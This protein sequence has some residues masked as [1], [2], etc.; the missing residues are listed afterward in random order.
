MFILHFAY[1]PIVEE[2]IGELKGGIHIPHDQIFG[3][4]DPPPHR[5]PKIRH[6]NCAAQ[7]ENSCSRFLIYNENIQST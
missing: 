2:F 1:S 3:N 5:G 7:M 6:V 4:F